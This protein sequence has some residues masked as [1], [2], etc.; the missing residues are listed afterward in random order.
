MDLTRFALDNARVVGLLTV[1]LML[2]G[3]A[4]YLDFPSKEDPEVTVREA[5]VTAAFPGMP[6]ERIEEL[7]SRKIE[8]KIRLIPEVEHIKSTSKTGISITHV[9]VYDG[10]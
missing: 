2:A 9:V 6:P 8:K 4:V 3:V 1:L 7:I 5:V 10:P